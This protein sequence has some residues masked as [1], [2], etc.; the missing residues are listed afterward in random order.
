M[1][2][3]VYFNDSEGNKVCGILSNPTLNK[4]NLIVVLC[5][6]FSSSKGSKTYTTLS[7][8]LNEKRISSFRFDFFGHGESDGKFEDIT[9]SKAV[10]D[11]INAV[12]FLREKGYKK[13]GLFGSSFGGISSIIAA[14]K[15]NGLIFLALKS[16]VSDYLEVKN[17]EMTKKQIQEWKNKGYT[18]YFNKYGTKLKLNYSF[19]EDFKNNNGYEC[20]K[21]INIPALIVHGD[22]DETVPLEQSKKTSKLIKNC[23]LEIIK[24]ADHRYTKPEHFKKVIDLI[25]EFIFEN[26]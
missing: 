2:K 1:E 22:Y 17:K 4:E 3:K 5:H 15:L 10:D 8:V 23:R 24:G 11:I 16:P 13:I 9:I 20:A 25:S 7:K 26:I 12:E 19:F 18:F 21:K 6:G 14:S